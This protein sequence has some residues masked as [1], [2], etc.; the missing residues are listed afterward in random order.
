MVL[1]FQKI[2]V[3]IAGLSLSTGQED[4]CALHY[5][6]LKNINPLQI[7]NP[8]A[9]IALSVQEEEHIFK[10]KDQYPNDQEL[11]REIRKYLGEIQEKSLALEIKLNGKTAYEVFYNK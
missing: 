9:S 3:G 11:G 6:F 8:M 2:K 7:I 5:H 10:L 1:T 4:T